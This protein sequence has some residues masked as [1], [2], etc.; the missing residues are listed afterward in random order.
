M[1][2]GLVVDGIGQAGLRLAPGDPFIHAPGQV[3]DN[4]RVR[5]GQ[6]GRLFRILK[7]VVQLDRRLEVEVWLER[8]DELPVGCAPAVLAHPRALGDVEFALVRGHLA[9]H[10]GHERSTVEAQLR[11]LDAGQ[12]EER[13]HQVL[14][15]VVALDAHAGR[16][17]AGVADDERHDQRR[18]VHAVVVEVAVVVV[19]RLAVVAVDDDDGVLGQPA[20]LQRR[21]DALD[22]GVHI[23]DGAIVLGN[24]VLL[25]GDARRHPARKEVTEGL[26]GHHRLHGLV[27]L[28]ELVTVIEHALI[29]RRRQV[30]RVRVHVAQ[31]EEEGIALAR[32]AVQLGDGHVVEILRLG[33]APLVPASPAGKL[34]VLVE[35][36]RTGVAAKADTGCVV[37]F[38]A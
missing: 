4:L 31:E 36:A 24:D 6:V 21:E 3:G 7:E 28:V 34:D 25:V 26:E 17:L 10:H 30:G 19:E 18:L 1:P 5:F 37:A 27:A 23:G 32:Q 20:R 22:G 38:L 35:A 16:H 2:A 14:V 11:A 33:A 12:L 15:L 29:G 9:A 13:R 8:H